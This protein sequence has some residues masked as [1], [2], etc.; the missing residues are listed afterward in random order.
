M[1]GRKPGDDRQ[2]GQHRFEREHGLDAFAGRDD[3]PRLRGV[4]GAGARSAGQEPAEGA[5]W[6]G[7]WRLGGALRSSQVG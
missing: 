6:I 3:A 1:V 5:A 7:Q 2:I 4:A